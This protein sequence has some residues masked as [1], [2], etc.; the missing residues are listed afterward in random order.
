ME[1]TPGNVVIEDLGRALVASVPGLKAVRHVHVWSI[2]SGKPVATLEIVLLPGA[3]AG[4]VTRGIKTAL[5]A[6]YGI[7]HST[8]EIVW[9]EQAAACALAPDSVP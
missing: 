4:A 9:D 8:I 1:G 3:D 6:D 7:T 5:G 2:T